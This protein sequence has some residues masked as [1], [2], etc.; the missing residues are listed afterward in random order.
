MT[1]QASTVACHCQNPSEKEGPFQPSLSLLSSD[2]LQQ[3]S[4]KTHIPKTYTHQPLHQTG[5]SSY[6]EFEANAESPEGRPEARSPLLR[7]RGRCPGLRPKAYRSLGLRAV[8]SDCFEQSSC[9][10]IATTV[11]LFN[12]RLFLV[13]LPVSLLLLI[14]VVS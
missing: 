9:S 13:F 3:P 6:T 11:L 2:A 7:A 5:I 8:E 1:F 4:T 12:V 14:M 10:G